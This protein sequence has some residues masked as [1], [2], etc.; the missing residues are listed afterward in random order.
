MN[1]RLY[2]PEGYRIKISNAWNNSWNAFYDEYNGKLWE[3]YE[4]SKM[5]DQKWE[6]APNTFYPYRIRD[7]GEYISIRT[8]QIRC[9]KCSCNVLAHFQTSEKNGKPRLK[10]DPYCSKECTR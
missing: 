1:V 10:Y 7:R 3:W 6:H 4:Q 9:P 8:H 5:S 2:T